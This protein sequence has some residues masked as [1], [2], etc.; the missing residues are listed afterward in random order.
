MTDPVVGGRP[1]PWSVPVVLHEP[2]PTWPASAEQEVRTIRHALGPLSLAADHVGS[3]SVP[4]LAAK[5]VLDLLLQVPDS[6]DE[7]AYVPPLVALGYWLQVREPDWLEHRVLYRRTA[8]GS[9]WAVN[10]HVLSPGLGSSEIAR[11]LTFRD[12]L[13]SHPQD[14]DRYAAVKRELA[15]RPWRYVQDYADAKSEV[16]E[17]ILDRAAQ[18]RR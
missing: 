8:R 7:A 17:D 1:E 3:T 9:P 10:L 13:R 5:P 18:E 11:M 14:R 15:A 6:A 4:G 12:W 2:D 16:V